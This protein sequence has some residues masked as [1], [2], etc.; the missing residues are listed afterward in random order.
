MN[1]PN[2]F[3][4]LITVITYNPKDDFNEKILRYISIVNKIVIVD[5]ASATDISKYI[6][7]EYNSHFVIIKSS[8]N[9]G[10]AWGINQGI[11]YAQT[12]NYLYVLTFDQDSYPIDE[13]LQLYSGLFCKVDNIGLIGTTFSDSKVCSPPAVTFSEKSTLIT[14]GTLHTVSI[15]EEIGLY[16]EGLFID[17]VDFDFVLR[18]K[19]KFRVLRINE[20]L[21]Y[22]ELG[23]PLSRFGIKS[24][25]HNAMR[26]YYMARNHIIICKRYWR[27]FP[28]WILKKNCFFLISILRM[29]IVEKNTKEKFI[30]TI[31]GIHDAFIL[32][33]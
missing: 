22:H 28:I 18:V 11:L 2:Y 31:H 6:P 17:S 10:I 25:N 20:P 27:N 24:S 8:N 16:D 26:R 29:F 1:S 13:I 7:E 19:N 4:T 21:I 5:N 23:A 15:F 33:K 30:S 32:N 9:K 14:S 12:H 3:N